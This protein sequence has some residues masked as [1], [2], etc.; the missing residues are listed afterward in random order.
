[1]RKWKSDICG[2]EFDVTGEPFVVNACDRHLSYVEALA[3]NQAIASTIQVV[4]HELNKELGEAKYILVEKR[5]KDGKEEIISEK[6]LYN[7]LPP[8]KI[9]E[10]I[11]VD[12]KKQY[13]FSGYTE[14]ELE[15]L[16]KLNTSED[17]VIKG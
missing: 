9:V 13:E 8:E 4:E 1:M 16:E 7:Y 15:I 2:C 11:E 14:K 17:A 5:I 3:E 6:E 12:G 10:V